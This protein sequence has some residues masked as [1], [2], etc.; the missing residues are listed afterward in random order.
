LYQ[1]ESSQSTQSHDGERS[2]RFATMFSGIYGQTAQDGRSGTPASHYP[3]L[4]YNNT[5]PYLW[6]NAAAS[7][8]AAAA[9]LGTYPKIPVI[10][11]KFSA[12]VLI[13]L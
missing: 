4:D 10:N 3:G 11:A 9:S 1:T 13:L 8:P 6:L 2:G 7:N 12:K 5:N